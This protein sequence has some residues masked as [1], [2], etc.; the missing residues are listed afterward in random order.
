MKIS[1]AS[2]RIGDVIEELRRRG[3]SSTIEVLE[4]IGDAVLHE[5]RLGDNCDTQHGY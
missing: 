4:Y 1:F 2:A 5:C 3:G